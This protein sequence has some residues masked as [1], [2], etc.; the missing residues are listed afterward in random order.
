MGKADPLEKAQALIEWQGEPVIYHGQKWYWFQRWS[1]SRR[2]AVEVLEDAGRL[3]R[4]S[5]KTTG[6]VRLV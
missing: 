1:P 5:D 3:V 2:R 6:L 4:W